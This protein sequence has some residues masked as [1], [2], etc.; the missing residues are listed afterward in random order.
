MSPM[1]SD[2]VD[3]FLACAQA[4]PE[5]SAIVTS[6]GSITYGALERR[7]RAFAAV[8]A[9]QPSPKV[10][11][12]LPQSTDAYA[13]MFAAGLAGGFYTPLNMASPFEKMRRIASQLEPDIVV[14]P[15]QMTQALA[16]PGAR[17]IDP[18]TLDETR[19]FDGGGTRHDLAY[20]LFTSG[21]TG[22]PKG[23]M[24]PRAAL[25]HYTGWLGSLRFGTGDRV[26]Q[27]AN[28]A[29]D[30]SV[31]DIYGALCH[32]AALYPLDVEGDRLMPARFVKRNEI[33]V[34]SS[35]PSAVGV[36]MRARQVT[37]ANLASVRLF[38]F[39]GEPLLK[40]HLDALFAAAP[41]AVVQNTYG[42]TEATV[43]MTRIGL[44]AQTYA[45]HCTS[46]VALGDAIAGMELV[47]SGGPD[48]DEGEIV[49]VGPQLARGYW[50]DGEKTATAFRAVSANDP[51]LGYFTGDWAWRRGGDLFFRERID[52]QVKV[53][54]FR[55]ELDEV[56][57]AIRASGYPVACV[58]KRG[59]ALAAIVEA[60]AAFDEADLRARLQS[61]LEPHAIPE[62]IVA[63]SALPLNENGKLDRKRAAELMEERISRRD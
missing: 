9:E 50:R 1:A 63:A 32:G 35:T 38:N 18:A 61:K 59:E 4:A 16:L 5:A 14:G 52:F 46:S 54:G 34:W 27:H 51:R 58:F 31:F 12:A 42:P 6:T 39:C 30:L 13:C 23:V 49:I 7:V 2:V 36:M 45:D 40:E 47:L 26:A 21:S 28:I 53:R 55:V 33:T 60:D 37:A 17:A 44:D 62:R 3:L 48:A 25:A 29:F 41:Q 57:S 15:P 24:I 10:L 43:S 56:A 19:R 22:E 11:V 8:F 20:V